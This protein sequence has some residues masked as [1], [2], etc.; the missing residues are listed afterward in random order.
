[1]HTTIQYTDR[2]D[3]IARISNGAARDAVTIPV[4]WNDANVESIDHPAIADLITRFR[5][6]IETMNI[7]PNYSEVFD[8]AYRIELRFPAEFTFIA[9]DI[10]RFAEVNEQDELDVTLTTFPDSTGLSINVYEPVEAE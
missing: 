9:R 8:Y 3:R 7:H 2:G 10:Q 1:M 6:N 4:N 5:S